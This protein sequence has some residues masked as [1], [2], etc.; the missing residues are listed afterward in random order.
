MKYIYFILLLSH[1]KLFLFN[2]IPEYNCPKNRGKCIKN[3]CECFEEFW[4][5]KLEENIHKNFLYCNYK[6]RNRFSM[7]ALEFFIPIGITHILRGRKILFFLK[8]F[9][10]CSP[11]ILIFIGFKIYQNENKEENSNN[12]KDGEEKTNLINKQKN[13]DKNKDND[14]YKIIEKENEDNKNDKNNDSYTSEEGNDNENLS[15]IHTANSKHI[16]LQCLN[17]FLSP[18]VGLFILCY[19]IQHIIDLIGYCFGLYRDKGNVP[20]L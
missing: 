18:I 20:F 10:L 4:T 3:K 8:I 17:S 19:F 2:C 5:L 9:F 15:G 13:T 6:R 1:I 12:I 7:L 16:P 14:K 11:I